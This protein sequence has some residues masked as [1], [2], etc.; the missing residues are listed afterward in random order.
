[1]CLSKEYKRS[2]QIETSGTP[3]LQGTLADVILIESG[4]PGLVLKELK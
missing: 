4:W 2:Y 3:D 1:M